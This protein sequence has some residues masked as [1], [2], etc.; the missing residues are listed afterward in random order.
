MFE[1]LETEN[2]AI[3]SFVTKGHILEVPY[4]NRFLAT[5]KSASFGIRS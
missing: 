1:S 2:N 3:H 4:I 5:I